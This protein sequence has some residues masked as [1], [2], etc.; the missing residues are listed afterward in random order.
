MQQTKPE[1]HSGETLEDLQ[2]GGLMLIQKKDGF[3]FGTDAVL[4]ADFAKRIHSKNTLDLCTGTG[5]VPILLAAKS[6]TQHICG[7]EIQHDVADAAQRSVTLNGLDSRISIQC[8]DLKNALSYYPC[9][10]FDLVTC[11]PPYM[12]SGCAILNDSDNKIISRHEVLCTLDDITEVSSKL[13]KHGG[14]LV[15][16]HRPNRLADVMCSM[17]KNRIEPK[18]IRFVHASFEKPPVLFLTDGMLGANSEIK[19]LPPLLLYD[20]EGHETPEL[21]SIYGRE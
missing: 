6:D 2:C 16:V 11:N 3:R 4:L 8:G 7:I 21:K 18:Y 5:I 12:K 17:R 9:A 13:L 10:S 15:M 20:K 14:H 1:L 19:I